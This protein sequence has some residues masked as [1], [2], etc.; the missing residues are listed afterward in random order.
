[1]AAVLHGIIFGRVAPS[2][3]QRR[4]ITAPALVVGHTADPIHPFADS[5][6]LSRELANAEFV[7]AHT[8]LE[9]RFRPDRLNALAT[10]FALRC[11]DT[12]ARGR[13]TGA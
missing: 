7:R 8:V 9:W 6:M 5:R 10:E 13:R 11:W 3:R 4:A 1:V 2:S 12:R